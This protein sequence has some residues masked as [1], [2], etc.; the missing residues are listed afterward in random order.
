MVKLKNAAG[1][2]KE[3]Y[4]QLFPSKIPN[5]IHGQEQFAESGDLFKKLNPADATVLCKVT[6]SRGKDLE[7][8]VREY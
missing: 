7:E 4:M 3:A 5:W 1:I 8:A 2:E 6:R